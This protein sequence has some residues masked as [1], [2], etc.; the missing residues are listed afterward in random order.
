MLE[1]TT[2]VLNTFLLTTGPAKND[3]I[4]HMVL[5]NFTFF[6]MEDTEWKQ[7]SEC[8]PSVIYTHNFSIGIM[9]S[10]SLNTKT[11]QNP[12]RF[13]KQAVKQGWTWTWT[14]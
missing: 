10:N 14:K 1:E 12:G 9:Y 13:K 8:F 5:L 11:E 6:T 7:L 4:L 2:Q 3:D